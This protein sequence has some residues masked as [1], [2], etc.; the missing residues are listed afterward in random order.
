MPN[1]KKKVNISWDEL[2]LKEKDFLAKKKGSLQDTFYKKFGENK[3]LTYYKTI[4][5]EKLKDFNKLS[6]KIS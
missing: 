6:K 5:I 3:G 1:T 4:T 2:S